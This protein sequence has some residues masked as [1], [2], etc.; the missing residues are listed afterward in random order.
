MMVFWG[1]QNKKR[2][3]FYLENTT[4]SRGNSQLSAQKAKSL[5]EACRR[6]GKMLI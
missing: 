4:V 1:E 3:T 5:H 6:D 2:E